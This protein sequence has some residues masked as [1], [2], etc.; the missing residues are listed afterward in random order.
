MNSQSKRLCELL[1]GAA[2]GLS[3][4]AST[5]AQSPTS[6]PE[7]GR[8]SSTLR[9]ASYPEAIYPHGIIPD[10]DRGYVIHH[11]IEVN[12]SP[13]TAMVVMYDATGKR[14]REDRIWPGGAGK[15]GIR[16]TAATRDGAILAAGWAIM[17]DGSIPGYIA[18]TDLQGTTIQ[19]VETGAFKPE[20]IC[21]ATD[22]TVW[23]LGKAGRSDGAPVPDTGVVRHYS[24][25]KGLLQSFLPENTVQASKNSEHPW[26]TPFGS[27]LRCGKEKVSVYLRFTDEYAEIN[28]STFELKRWKLDDSVVQQR[29]ASGL[30]VTEDGRVYVSFRVS[31]ISGQPQ[32]TGLYE[33]KAESGK[34]IA[35][36]LPVKGTVT[37]VE[38]DKMPAPGTFTMLWG[39]DGNKLV[40]WRT[41]GMGS[42][43]SWVNVS[44]DESTD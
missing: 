22:G 25:E 8:I 35:G 24:F 10:W 30:A 42:S 6:P 37:A 29:Q 1:L 34:R 13:D 5:P 14:V 12:N 21:E 9:T 2:L 16:R 40:V 26:F 39:A 20:Q 41:E 33:I 32:V 28:T 36:L 17:Q 31:G 15:V 7:A 44:R 23:S 38:R 4:S 3:L 43:L 27:F 19:S 18:K 11:E